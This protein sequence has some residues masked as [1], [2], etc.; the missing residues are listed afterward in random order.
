MKIAGILLITALLIIPA[1]TARRLA[2]TPEGMAAIAAAIGVVAVVAG[3][4]FSA[5]FDTPSGP[6]IVVM[7]CA[8][9]T[10]VLAATGVSVGHL[11]RALAGRK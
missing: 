2:G 1:A 5:R 4:A 10:V 7:A 8:V 11:R 9:F 3:L 6:S